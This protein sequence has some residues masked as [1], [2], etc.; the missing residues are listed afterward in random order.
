MFE[1]FTWSIWPTRNDSIYE[2][3]ETVLNVNQLMLDEIL[4]QGIM[5]YSVYSYTGTDT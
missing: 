2:K 5:S 4:K 1:K 3:S